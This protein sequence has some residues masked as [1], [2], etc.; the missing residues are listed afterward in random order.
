MKTLLFLSLALAVAVVAV[1]VPAPEWEPVSLD[2]VLLPADVLPEQGHVIQQDAKPDAGLEKQAQEEPAKPE[3]PAQTSAMGPAAVEVEPVV[4]VVEQVKEKEVQQ[5]SPEEP[6]LESN[7]LP[8]VDPA[9]EEEIVPKDEAVL[10]L[11]TVDEVNAIVPEVHPMPGKPRVEV[12]AEEKVIPKDEAMLGLETGEEEEE[13]AVVPEVHPIPGR[14]QL[15]EEPTMELEPE[16]E[17]E[18]AARMLGNLAEEEEDYDEMVE[19]PQMELEPLPEEVEE[20]EKAAMLE[21][22][23]LRVVVEEPSMELEPLATGDEDLT[24]QDDEPGTEAERDEEEEL[25]MG[26]EGPVAEGEMVVDVEPSAVEVEEEEEEGMRP[27]RPVLLGRSRF[28]QRPLMAG[29]T[30]RQAMMEEEPDMWVGPE[31][32]RADPEQEVEQEEE[33]EVEARADD[34]ESAAVATAG[35]EEVDTDDR[36]LVNVAETPEEEDAKMAYYERYLDGELHDEVATRRSYCGGVTIE[37]RCYQFFRG[38]KQAWDAEFYC[39]DHFPNGHLASVTNSFIHRQMMNLMAQN[40]GYT[41][42]W[43][44]GLRYLD[45]GRFI[46]LDGAQWKYADWLVGEPNDTSGREDCVELLSDSK[47][48]DMPCLDYRAFICSYPL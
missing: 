38:P 46:W 3:Q 6:A 43:V 22:Q 48:N 26:E 36:M 31:V 33:E 14:P 34:E 11:E 41:R 19:Q 27:G 13:N 40:G 15:V 45:T 18:E 37:G 4:V 17:E 25:L 23:R 30:L 28:A 9:V 8:E 35:E 7:L 32:V 42:T 20:E 5:E 44:G 39:Q 1:P 10:G 47:F 21:D 2:E 29:M 24:S 16:E 12:V